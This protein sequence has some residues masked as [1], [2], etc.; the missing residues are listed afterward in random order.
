MTEENPYQ[1]P[2][3]ECRSANFVDLIRH[4]DSLLSLLFSFDGRISRRTSWI[5]LIC[6]Y[7]LYFLIYGL[8]FYVFYV[9]R[10]DQSDMAIA[11]QLLG[12][13]PYAWIFFAI[14]AK[15]WHDRNKSTFWL[16]LF[17]VPVIGPIWTFVELGFLR[18]TEGPNKYG[19]DPLSSLPR[20]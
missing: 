12:Y 13:I 17:L 14:I 10:P 3:E 8:I 2:L 18:G 16:L 1:S 15:R 6:S 20:S 9:D 5:T 19:L 7:L 11:A 4:K